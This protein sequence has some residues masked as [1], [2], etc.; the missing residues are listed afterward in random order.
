MA[1]QKVKKN[2]LP[3]QTLLCVLFC[4][5]RKYI[6]V[7]KAFFK[8]E[9]SVDSV[10]YRLS[11]LTLLILYLMTSAKLKIQFTAFEPLTLQY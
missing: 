11:V 2:T 8:T 3:K 4:Y 10:I 9:N 1:K 7:E 5:V 6:S